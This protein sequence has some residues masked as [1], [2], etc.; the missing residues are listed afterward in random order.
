M[1]K[2][3][4]ALQVSLDG[5]IEGPN[6]ELDWVETWEDLFD[7][8]PGSTR[9]SWAAGCIRATSDTGEPSWPTPRAFCPS[10][11]G[12]HRRARSTQRVSG[13]SRRLSRV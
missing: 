6:G 4:A 13:V 11:A 8:L 2:I 5:F 9:V 10:Q 12:S 1:R 3:I 7:L